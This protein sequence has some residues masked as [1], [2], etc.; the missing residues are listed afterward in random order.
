MSNQEQQLLQT[1]RAHVGEQATAV[2]AR[3]PVN[4]P[5]IRNWCDAI[6]DTNPVYTEV[7]ES[8]I[9]APAAM[10]DVWTM[11]GNIP[12]SYD[13]NDPRNKVFALLNKAGYRTVVGANTKEIY[14][15]PLRLGELLT[16][17]MT[18]IDVSDLKTTGLGCGYFVSTLTEFTNQQ[19]ELV[20]SWEFRTFSFK[21]R[22]R[23][24]K[25]SKDQQ[26]VPEHLQ[27]RPR[28]GKM[29]ETEFFWDGCDQ[30]ELRIQQCK[31][32]ERLAHP[33]VVRC[34]ECGSYD[35]G[36]R[37]ASGK[38]TLHA[39]VEPVHPPMPF[40]QYPY[41][42]GVVELEEGTRLITNIV[43]CA[44]EQVEIG[45]PLELVFQQPDPDLTLP[46][47]RPAVPPINK[48]TLNF[49]DL[50]E[51]QTL[52]LYPIDVTTN[53]VVGGAIA[54]RDFEDIHHEV[55]AAKR[56][57]LKDVFMNVLTTNGICARYVSEWAGPDARVKEIDIRL[58][59]PN[60]VGDTMTLS[61]TLVSKQRVDGKG[62]V[63]LN[64]RVANSMGNHV[65]G[66]VTLEFPTQAAAGGS[67]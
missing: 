32:C 30:G 23:S 6:G 56:A 20:G 35:L 27:V 60:V 19:G 46:M 7:D 58:G 43:H 24:S 18:L 26:P 67:L 37:V 11:A 14:C 49:D 55:A 59:A 57:G 42:C 25:G 3:D 10:L 44:P 53:L 40:M 12:R 15:R 17:K 45:M 21:P 5:T 61:A 4:L 47:F 66:T 13:P 38:A 33:P 63:T 54:T 29:Q 62:R 36:H 9:E 64:L 16:G 39:F 2:V 34:P 52:P 48:T 51:G 22:E 28:P 31:G 65:T 8:D 50:Q 41:I 1:L